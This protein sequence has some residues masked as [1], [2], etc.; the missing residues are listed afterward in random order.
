[1]EEHVAQGELH[2]GEDGVVVQAGA[3]AAVPGL[4]GDDDTLAVEHVAE[5]Q[6]V[7]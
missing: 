2:D 1:M 3:L 7:S 5:E 4:H 6:L